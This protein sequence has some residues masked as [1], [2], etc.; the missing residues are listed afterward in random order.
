MVKSF[1]MNCKRLE[2]IPGGSAVSLP[3]FR[4]KSRTGDQVLA[5]SSGCLWKE[6]QTEGVKDRRAKHPSGDLG[7]CL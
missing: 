7:L 3:G 5:R 2:S 1:K 4:N 6:L